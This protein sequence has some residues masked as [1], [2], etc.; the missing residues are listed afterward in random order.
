MVGSKSNKSDALKPSLA[1]LKT[2]IATLLV[3][4]VVALIAQRIVSP[5]QVG[6]SLAPLLVL[7]IALLSRYLLSRDKILAS[8]YVLTIGVWLTVTAAAVFTGGVHAPA[9]M[10]Y[11]A[12]I[13]GAAWLIHTRVAWVMTALTMAATIGTGLA[14]SWALL[15]TWW[16]SSTVMY[17]GDQVVIYVLTATLAA[18]LVRSYQNRVEELNTVIAERQQALDTLRIRDERFTLLFDRATDG[19][20]VL[21]TEGTIVAANDAFARMHGYT[22]HEMQSVNLR[23]LDTPD[24]LRALP[25]RLQRILSGEALTFEVY[26]YHKDGHVVPLE[27]TSSLIAI[28]EERLIQ[29]FHRDISQRKLAEEEINHLAFYDPLTNLPNRRLLL[30]RLTQVIAASTRHLAKSAL[31]FVDLDNFKRL[32]DTKGHLQGDALLKQVAQRL[33]TCI[34]KIDTAAR[35]G[36]DEFAVLLTDLSRSELE[37]ATQAECVAEKILATLNQDYA[38]EYGMQYSTSSIGITL[39]GGNPVENALDTLKRGELAMYEAKTAGRNALR[40]FD[41]QMQVDV[42]RHVA[43]EADLREAVLSQ[44]FVLFYQSQIVGAGRIAGVE[45]LLRWQHPTR[46]LVSPSEFI[47]LAE[48]T[49]LILPIGLWVLETACRQL[50]LWANRPELAHLTLSV[51]VS[52]RQFHQNEFVEQ[53][54]TVLSRSG[55]NP[56]RLK[57][58]LT[59][60]MLVQDVESVIVKMSTLKSKGVS[61]SLDDFGTGYSSLSYLKRLPLDQ[62]KIDQG[63][64]RNILT[65]SNDA[66]IA[67]MV[68]ALASGLGL[69]VIAEGVE[70]EAQ[71]DLLASLGCHYYQGYLFSRP[72]PLHEFEAL[73]A[74]VPTSVQAIVATTE[75]LPVNHRPNHSAD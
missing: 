71:R 5:D 25:Q 3:G 42:T 74:R 37:A 6:R 73:V 13:I 49:G 19:I 66:A 36:S 17:V 46:G 48:E 65:D 64:V 39:F 23:D 70:L 10:A 58:E 47:E 8:K 53:V 68:V 33:V 21:S 31:L 20:I 45:V 40:F 7:M 69:S 59:E 29:A 52:A 27:V 16:P 32:N 30:D 38:L 55:A 1:F 56:K 60:S 26:H 14:E 9:V 50:A 24:T 67:G 41:Q 12:I 22:P 18:F 28:G 43:L 2:S 34:R 51:N 57:L 15:P 62:L 44:Q 61:F 54:L 75:S 72:L 63:F 4:A 35:L 11:P